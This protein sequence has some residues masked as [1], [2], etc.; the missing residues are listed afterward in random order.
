MDTVKDCLEDQGAWAVLPHA[1]HTLAAAAVSCSALGDS[2]VSE[3]PTVTGRHG[4]TVF[5]PSKLSLPVFSVWCR[6]IVSPGS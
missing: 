4:Q 3:R 5:L 6:G 1:M 2:I